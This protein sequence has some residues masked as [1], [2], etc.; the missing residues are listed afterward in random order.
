[1][2]KQSIAG[3]IIMALCSFGCAVLFSGIGFHAKKSDKPV[4][5]WSGSK[6]DPKKVTDIPAYNRAYG[7]MWRI[8]AI[9]YWLSGVIS[10]VGVAGEGYTLAA[11]ILMSVACFPGLFFLIFQYIKIERKYIVK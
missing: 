6:V 10:C 3:A 7:V 5:F 2:D 9:P 1:M 11:A 8:Y 4:A